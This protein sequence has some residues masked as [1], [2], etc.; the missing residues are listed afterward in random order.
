MLTSIPTTIP[1]E[2]RDYPEWHRGRQTYAV[3]IVPLEDERILEIFHA[4]R[5]H[6]SGVLLESYRRQPHITLF[7]CGFLVEQSRYND[8]FS[9]PQLQGQLN[10]LKK[11]ALRHSRSRS[12]N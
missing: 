6:L 5:K 3:W 8:D 9:L 4:A 12:E 11:R 2:I 7:V 1:A 10:A